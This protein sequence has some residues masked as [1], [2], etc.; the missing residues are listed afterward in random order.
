MLYLAGLMGSY[1]VKVMKQLNA[2]QVDSAPVSFLYHCVPCISPCALCQEARAATVR[3]V[4]TLCP[5]VVPCVFPCVSS[6]VSHIFAQAYDLANPHM[7]RQYLLRGICV[8]YESFN[9]TLF[10][11]HV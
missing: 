7:P 10:L 1:R 5:C 3:R 11:V 8:A 4:F 9:S 6:H 2:P